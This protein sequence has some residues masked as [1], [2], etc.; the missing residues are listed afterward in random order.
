MV[1]MQKISEWL[2]GIDLNGCLHLLMKM[3]NILPIIIVHKY[4]TSY[5][6]N[7]FDVVIKK[8]R[9]ILMTFIN[10]GIYILMVLSNSYI[11]IDILNEFHK[12]VDINTSL[13][14]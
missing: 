7:F 11:I 9:C 14:T 5:H 10:Y 12:V 1:I 4:H 3:K 13:L 6:M 2:H 8:E